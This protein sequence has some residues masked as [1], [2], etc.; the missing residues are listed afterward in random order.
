MSGPTEAVI[1]EPVRTPIGRYG[2][3]FKSL[4]AVDL[5]VTALKGL[6]DRTQL[7]PESVRDVIL[8]HCYPSSEAPAI[9][10]VVALDAGLPVTVPG[11]QIDR[12]CG[13][14]LQAVIQACLQVSSGDHDLVV[15]G[16][17]ESM[18]NVVFYSTDMRWGGARTGIKVHDGLVRGRTTAGGR[19]Y[20]VPGGMLETAENLR[21]QYN[22]SRTE[23]D[24]LAATSHQ[25][26]VAAQKDG[27]FAE[28]I[29]P[30][31]V[32][33]RQG[34]QLIDTDEHPRA[35][36]TVESLAKLKPVLLQDDPDATVTAGNASG[37]NDAASMCVVTTREKAGELG[38]TPLVR[39]VSWAVAGV[40]PTVMGI[41]PVP[42]TELALARA[43]LR[44]ADIDLI[45]L[46]EAF[47]AQAIAVM[48]EWKFS[49][50]D[51]DRTNVLGSGI[52][53]GHPV[54][55]TG[56]RMLTTLARELN[57]RQARYGLETM[58]IGGGQ[59]LAAVFERVTSG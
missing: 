52:S 31:A 18:S 4:S 57:R 33:S 7:A 42:A 51:R 45:E 1:C 27:I 8:G 24:E 6:L 39:L 38:L 17:T 58:C 19:S 37:Q 14:G 2:G 23:Q 50:A 43:N 32:Q 25:R 20:P 9:G 15:A 53:L 35:D 21:R 10:R 29:I 26:A 55:A 56:A 13:S 59:G 44:L 34:E 30:V 48:R 54:G 5:G 12:R 3:M 16:G 41:G 46:N 22:I 49:A 28:E 11:M 36:T 40:P 47:A